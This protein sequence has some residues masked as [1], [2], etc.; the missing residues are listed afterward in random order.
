MALVGIGTGLG[1]AL[2][3]GIAGVLGPRLGWRLP[4]LVLSVPALILGM[5]IM[6]TVKDPIRGSCED[7]VQD[8]SNVISDIHYGRELASLN[9][10]NEIMDGDEGNYFPVKSDVK[11]IN[12]ANER[13]NLSKYYDSNAAQ[14][15]QQHM[16]QLMKR[17]QKELRI[18]CK[19]GFDHPCILTAKTLLST[20][21]VILSLFQGAPGCVPWGIVNT[22]LNDFLS[23][24]CGMTVQGATMT[25]LVFGFGNFIGILIGGIG[26]GYLYKKDARY[27]SLLSGLMA[28]FGCFPLWLLINYKYG[29]GLDDQ[30]RRISGWTTKSVLTE[31]VFVNFVSFLAGLG[32]GVTG[33][34]V[35]ATLQ[36]V[37][38]PLARGQA[39]AMLNIFDDFGR[40]FGPVFV[41]MLIRNLG[42]RR[43][44][45]N[46]GISGWILCGLLNMMA[47]FTVRADEDKTR[48][49]VLEKCDEIVCDNETIRNFEL[50][51]H[52]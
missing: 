13:Q 51:S 2:G 50:V 52:H 37:T 32:S 42:S 11:V 23:Q 48:Q 25:I 40:G 43:T 15:D 24:D 4:F 29:E 20:P 19:N 26:G 49:I 36:N 10:N 30:V 8:S 47:F 28:I 44:A 22:F 17:I 34:I 12:N 5:L 1:I 16:V 21:T 45:F 3:Q 41:A 6:F 14:S 31:L 18:K 27:P 7:T 33:P 38:P 46:V 9:D 35:K 39:F